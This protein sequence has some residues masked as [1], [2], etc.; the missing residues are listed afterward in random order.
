LEKL[1]WFR[2]AVE[3]FYKKLKH[4]MKGKFYNVSNDNI[5]K[6][7]IYAQQ[8]ASLYTRIMTIIAIKY[9]INLTKKRSSNVSYVKRETQ[10]NFKEALKISI[11][12]L[13]YMRNNSISEVIFV[14]NRITNSTF[15]KIPGRTY[16]RIAIIFRGKWYFDGN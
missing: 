15:P 14:L 3:E 10:I 6:Q 8:F 1:Y 16:K 4:T 2:W 5:F 7:S 11:R 13:L 9:N 12:E